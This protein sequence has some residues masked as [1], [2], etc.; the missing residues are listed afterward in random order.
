MTQGEAV[1]PITYYAVG[2]QKLVKSNAERIRK[3]PYANYFNPDV[4]VPDEVLDALKAPLD[5]GQALGKSAADLNRLLE[6][7]YLDGE[8]GYCGFDDGTGY[9]A[10]LVKFP[11][12]TAEM[13]RWWFWWHSFE[14]ERYS[15]WH[16]WCHADIWRSDPDTET[17]PGLSDVQRYVGSTHHINEYIGQDPL[18]IEI[19]FIDPAQWGLDTDRFDSA[20]ISGHACGNVLMKDSHIRLATMIHLIRDTDDGFELRSRYW[21][22]DAAE[23]QQPPAP[24]VPQLTEVE[25]FSGERQ[26]YEQLIHDQTE[27]THL[28]T[29]LPAIYQEF[30]PE[31]R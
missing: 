2:T 15:L 7:G 10:S 29:F 24:G 30:G 14:P 8:T 1:N 22:G 11:G 6:P 28:A 4:F 31:R 21:I 16:P 20:G 17:A 18:D 9:T 12:A 25:G 27:F 5:P 23:P 3:K 26:A 19:T 13:F